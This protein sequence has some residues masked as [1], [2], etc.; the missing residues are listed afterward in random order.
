MCRVL[1]DCLQEGVAAKLA[2]DLYCGA[3][4]PEEILR[5]WKRI[6]EALEQ[7]NLLSPS[8]TTIC[9]NSTTIL[10]WIWTQGQF[11]A[12]PHRI[13]ALTSCTPPETVRGLRSFIGMY[14]A[15]SRVLPNRSQ[16]LAPLNQAISVQESRAKVIWT[17]ELLELFHVAPTSLDTHKS[18]TLPRPTDQL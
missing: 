8:R 13:A 17:E 16:F 3:D 6:L 14:K 15:L 12:S 5:N 7:C 2:D 10:G 1:G 9:P 11:S 4:T 18:I